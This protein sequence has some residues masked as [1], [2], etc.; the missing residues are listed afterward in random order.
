MMSLS[1]TSVFRNSKKL[2]AVIVALLFSFSAF[3]CEI[4]GCSINGY[5]FGILP[6]SLKNHIGVRYTYRS[7]QS[8]HL[9]SEQLFILGNKSTEYYNSAELWGRFYLTK[10]L[11]LLVFVPF[12]HY[13]TNEQGTKTTAKGIGDITIVA[14]YTLY[15]DAAT[16][17]TN[18]KQSLLVGGGIKLPTGK[19]NVSKSS[20]ELNPS[21]N[22][23]TGSID[24]LSDIIYNCRYKRVGLNLDANY[25]INTTNKD[26]FK[27]GNRFTTAA[28]FFYWQDV[29]K[30]ITLLPNAGLLFENAAKDI[31]GD[32]VQNIS[33]GNVTYFAAGLEVYGGRLNVGATFNHPLSQNMFKDLVQTTNNFSINASIMF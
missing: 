19:F 31:H 28:K 22:A 1:G 13:L 5:Y 14:N 17:T 30:K 16:G 7:F 20:Q 8:Q 29:G 4:C 23:G 33:G 11:Q 27:Y 3:A 9:I 12:N 6:Q 18:F 10:K 21:I 25:R 26:D 2:L 32:E 15:N 24:F